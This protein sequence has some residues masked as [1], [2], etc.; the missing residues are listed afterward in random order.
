MR[1][2]SKIQ[3]GALGVL[4][5]TMTIAACYNPNIQSG[6][7]QCSSSGQPCPRGFTCQ[8]GAN[9]NV[10]VK[11]SGSDGTGGGGGGGMCVTPIAE[12]VSGRS[13]SGGCDEIC[14]TG[15]A[16]NERCSVVGESIACVPDGRGRGMVGESCTVKGKSDDCA[17]GLLCLE[18]VAAVCGARCA[19]FCA[20][21]ADCAAGA[22][23]AVKL[24]NE[25]GEETL[26]RV[27]DVPAEACNPIYGEASKCHRTDRPNTYG[28]YVSDIEYPDE[29]VCDCVTIN[30]TTKQP[31]KENEVCGFQRGCEPGLFCVD[32]TR[33]RVGK[34]LRV[35]PLKS[36]VEAVKICGLGVECLQ[37][38]KS[39]LWGTCG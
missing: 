39:K 2:S 5:T 14:Q 12:C 16:C 15:C 17:P 30:E 13:S 32:R 34:C 22:H 25:D 10:C 27:C 35:C 28:C 18:E 26:I 21:D 19:R 33:S 23:C 3:L 37:I 4:L 11:S 36:P 31:L 6:K 24:L 8:V 9:A 29:A 20:T 1:L 7:L 38:G